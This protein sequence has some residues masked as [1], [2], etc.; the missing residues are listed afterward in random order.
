MHDFPPENNM[1]DG[2]KFPLLR[3]GGFYIQ[4]VEK[5]KYLR[6]IINTKLDDDDDIQIEIRN[7]FVIQNLA[8]RSIAF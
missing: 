5:C 4:F 7:L 1:Q 8:I 6:H 2:S 3:A